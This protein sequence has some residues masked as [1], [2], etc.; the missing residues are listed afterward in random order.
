MLP[1]YLQ[2]VGPPITLVTLSLPFNPRASFTACQPNGSIGTVVAIGSA[3]GLEL[4]QP[5]F[6]EAR[7]TL[8]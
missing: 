7:T 6:A 4:G 8:R 5:G 3:L 1:T 2:R